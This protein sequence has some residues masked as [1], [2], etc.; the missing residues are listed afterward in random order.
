MTMATWNASW[1]LSE[2]K[3]RFTATSCMGNCNGLSESNVGGQLAVTNVT[4]KTSTLTNRPQERQI[5]NHGLFRVDSRDCESLADLI[6]GGPHPS[7]CPNQA[8]ALTTRRG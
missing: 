7:K 3:S 8:I 5:R 6:L 4:S 1:G 2:A